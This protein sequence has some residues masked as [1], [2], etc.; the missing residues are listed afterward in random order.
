MHT[1]RAVISGM[2]S[3]YL[4]LQAVES[5]MIVVI[6][7]AIYSTEPQVF[8]NA[9][10]TAGRPIAGVSISLENHDWLF[11]CPARDKE[12]V[13]HGHLLPGT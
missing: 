12:L 11:L 3:G 7:K 9:T 6:R 4:E 8:F 2:D 1:G 10:L 5:R 13:V